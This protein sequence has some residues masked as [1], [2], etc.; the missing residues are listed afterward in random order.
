MYTLRP[1][2]WLSKWVVPHASHFE[3][4]ILQ[5]FIVSKHF[6]NFIST[7]LAGWSKF[8]LLGQILYSRLTPAPSPMP[9]SKR[10]TRKAAYRIPQPALPPGV[11]M[12]SHSDQWDVKETLMDKEDDISPPWTFFLKCG[13]D[14]WSKLCCEGIEVTGREWSL[15]TERSRD[16]MREPHSPWERNG[17]W[18]LEQ[19]GFC[20][21]FPVLVQLPHI[22]IPVPHVP[23]PSPYFLVEIQVYSL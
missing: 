12:W 9:L 6:I 17:E 21:C 18:V 1:F 5:C 15:F 13:S 23:T 19:P 8:H 16:T 7:T 3:A 10:E 22:L 14:D 11:A 2:K 20:G 4:N